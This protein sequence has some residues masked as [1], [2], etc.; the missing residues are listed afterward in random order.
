MKR[1]YKTVSG[2]SDAEGWSILLDGR[3]IRTP[4][5]SLL[6]VPSGPLAEHIAFEWDAQRETIDPKTMP[7]TRLANTVLDGVTPKRDSVVAEIAAYGE[8]DLI[9]YRATDPPELV[10]RQAAAWNPLIDWAEQRLSAQLVVTDGILHQK[11]SAEALLALKDAV[12]ACSD[13]QLA[14]LHMMVSITGSLVIGLA[15]L[16]GRLGVDEAWAAGQL[17]ELFQ[18]ERWGEDAEAAAVRLARQADLAHAA[19]FLSFLR[20]N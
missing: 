11:Q 6:R 7:L 18:A 9:C 16:A 15:L 19:S 10:V 2:V 8:S 13:W 1:F 4:A 17:D 5:K 14:P 12:E 3:P 20:P